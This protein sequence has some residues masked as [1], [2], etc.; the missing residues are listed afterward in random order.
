MD[1]SN[2][3]WDFW[4]L[5]RFSIFVGNREWPMVDG[6]QCFAWF[7]VLPTANKVS[8]RKSFHPHLHLTECEQFLTQVFERCTEVIHRVVDNEKPVVEAVAFPD[9]Y[10]RVLQVVPFDIQG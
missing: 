5:G 1:V 4:E 2:V 6:R 10:G 3:D 8:Q 9:G 7:R